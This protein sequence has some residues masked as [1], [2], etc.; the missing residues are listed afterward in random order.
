MGKERVGETVLF[1]LSHTRGSQRSKQSSACS[2]APR[3]QE[4]DCYFPYWTAMTLPSLE[5]PQKAKATPGPGEALCSRACLE[6]AMPHLPSRCELR[7]TA[8]FKR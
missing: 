3:T 2:E 6:E 5:W 4:K 7:V 8:P 1:G